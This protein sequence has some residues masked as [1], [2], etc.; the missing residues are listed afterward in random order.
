MKTG[1]AYTP[2]SFIRRSDFLHTAEGVKGPNLLAY[3][4]QPAKLPS[5]QEAPINLRVSS[6]PM[7]N[8]GIF[9]AAFSTAPSA[10]RSRKE[11]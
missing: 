9:K 8:G 5:E 2:A 1:H 3:P 4:S 10:P 6:F 7:R 11:V